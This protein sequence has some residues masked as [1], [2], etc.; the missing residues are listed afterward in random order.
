MIVDAVNN[1]SRKDGNPL[2]EGWQSSAR[3]FA[4]LPG[5]NGIRTMTSTIEYPTNLRRTTIGFINPEIDTA[6]TASTHTPTTAL[7]NGTYYWHARAS[8][9]IWSDYSST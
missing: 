2:K 4:I 9:G 6:M 5:Q 8:N 1:E 7:A 3:K